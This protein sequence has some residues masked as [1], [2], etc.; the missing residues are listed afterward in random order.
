MYKEPPPGLHIAADE[1]DI[2]KV[3][4]QI[5]NKVLTF[6]ECINHLLFVTSIFDKVKKENHTKKEK[7]DKTVIISLLEFHISHGPF[8]DFANTVE[9]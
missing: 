5:R 7:E 8:N 3:C 1:D 6:K 2:T 9:F 4:L